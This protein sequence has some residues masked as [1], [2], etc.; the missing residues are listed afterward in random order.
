MK[1][2]LEALQLQY[3]V[4]LSGLHEENP[5]FY[6]F[7]PQGVSAPYVTVNMIAQ[8]HSAAMGMDGG[9]YEDN[10]LQFTLV[11]AERAG[12]ANLLTAYEALKA[13]F[14]EAALEI[15]GSACV[16]MRRLNTI[17][18]IP[19]PDAMSGGWMITVDYLIETDTDREI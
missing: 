5:L 16:R 18:P 12:I 9:E 15:D 11:N 1:G 2:L 3:A 6:G 14:D 19:D 8:E 17:G 13:T 10:Y 7:A 4:I